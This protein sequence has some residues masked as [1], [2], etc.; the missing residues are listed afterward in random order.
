MTS[1]QKVYGMAFARTILSFQI[2]TIRLS[3]A[4][5]CSLAGFS[6]KELSLSMI[7]VWSVSQVSAWKTP[8]LVLWSGGVPNVQMGALGNSPDY[9]SVKDEAQSDEPIEGSGGPSRGVRFW[10]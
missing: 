4:T 10:L 1:C 6:T 7:A 5:S 3:M 9:E 8:C 2:Y